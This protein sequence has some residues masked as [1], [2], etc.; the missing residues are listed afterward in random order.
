MMSHEIRTP[1]NGVLGTIGL[2]QNTDLSKHQYKLITTA[3][4]SAEHLL[5]LI[6]DILDFSKLEAGRIVWKKSIS[7]CPIWSRARSR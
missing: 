2:L 3:R 7:I 5:S 1:M 6:N 4:E